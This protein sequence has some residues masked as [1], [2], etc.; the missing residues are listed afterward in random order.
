MT[1]T[2]RAA[3]L[4]TV[5]RNIIIDESRS[6]WAFVGSGG[7]WM[8]PLSEPHGPDEVNAALDRLLLG[9]AGTVVCRAPRRDSAVLPPGPY[10]R[11]DR[12]GVADRRAP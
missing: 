1:P 5:A 11:P 2:T 4:F 6:A 3:W 10:D 12:R 7:R 8:A 9:D